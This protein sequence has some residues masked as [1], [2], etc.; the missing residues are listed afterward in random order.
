MHRTASFPSLFPS[1]VSR[2]RLRALSVLAAAL[3]LPAGWGTASA[4]QAG[5]VPV[6]TAGP[7]RGATWEGPES[8]YRL[9]KGDV[10]E[11]SVFGVEQF[12]YEV[13][14]GSAGTVTLPY[15]GPVPAGGATTEEL[16]ERLRAL[17]D[18]K[19]FHDPQ[20]SV[21]VKEYRAAPVV[22]LGAVSQPGTYQKTNSELTLIDAL[23]KAGGVSAGAG[24]FVFVQRRDTAGGEPETIKISLNELF[25]QGVASL[26]MPLESGDIVNVPLRER[27]PR[28][29]YYV[30][31]EVGRPGVFELEGERPVMLT[32]AVAGAGGTLR[33]AKMSKGILVRI[34]EEGR[35]QEMAINFKK[36][37]NGKQPDVEV[38]DQDIIFIPGSNVK[39]IG[40]GLL[41]VIPGTA[42]A[43]TTGVIR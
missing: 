19:L 21:L 8:D 18:G 12:R 5:E 33:T 32:Q 10:I 9:G 38:K 16:S 25:R 39:T 26:N 35:R 27:E 42:Q 14:I 17:L 20:V 34:D 13:R 7:D 2:V 30:I 31:G 37:L 15:V 22:I 29:V 36:M 11:I 28:K 24:E 23:A 3:W 1:R 41:G 40:Y 43:T 4:Q 6:A